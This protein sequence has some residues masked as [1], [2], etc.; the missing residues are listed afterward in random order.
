MNDSWILTLI[1]A[2]LVIWLYVRFYIA[3]IRIEKNTK[4]SAEA[5]VWMAQRLLEKGTV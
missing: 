5:A 3:I 2:G 4:Q 1:G